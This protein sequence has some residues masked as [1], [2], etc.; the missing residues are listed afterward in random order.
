MKWGVYSDRERIYYTVLEK[1]EEDGRS[2]G[3]VRKSGYE[4]K[5]GG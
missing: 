1:N 5:G 3:R 2:K 4:K